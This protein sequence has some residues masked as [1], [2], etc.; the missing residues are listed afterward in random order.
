M[1]HTVVSR[2]QLLLTS[3]NCSIDLEE[4]GGGE[5]VWPQQIGIDL[6]YI[7]YYYF[8]IFMIVLSDTSPLV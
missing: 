8:Y 2:Y 3:D 1:V 4:G 5:K 6:D 7:Y